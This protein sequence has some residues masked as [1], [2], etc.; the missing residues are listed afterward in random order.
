MSKAVARRPIRNKMMAKRRAVQT[1]VPTQA[2]ELLAREPLVQ[3]HNAVLLK[4]LGHAGESVTGDH[5]LHELV[6][7]YQ[8]GHVDLGWSRGRHLPVENAH[9]KAVPVDNVADSAVS[10]S[11]HQALIVG[12]GVPQ[13]CQGVVPCGIRS[14]S[15]AHS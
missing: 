2:V 14:P 9:G 6:H 5:V 7:E 13:G 10:P 11:E 12:N 15:G 3:L 8:P 4:Q 1:E